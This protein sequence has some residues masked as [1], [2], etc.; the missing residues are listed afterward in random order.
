MYK[1]NQRAAT[2]TFAFR[3][4]LSCNTRK[5]ALAANKKRCNENGVIQPSSL[6]EYLYV[7]N[8]LRGNRMV[9]RRVFG[10]ETVA[11]Y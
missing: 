8:T 4:S 7:E 9:T 11:P 6:H 1:G 10:L 3:P 5:L 2:M